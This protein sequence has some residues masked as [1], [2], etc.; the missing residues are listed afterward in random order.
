MANYSATS[1]SSY[2][3]VKNRAAFDEWLATVAYNDLTVLETDDPLRVGLNATNGDCSGF[4]IEFEDEDGESRN[5]LEEL[6]K[7]LADGEV[8]VLME[9]GSEKCRYI[10][11]FAVAV[12]ADPTADGG[13][14]ILEVNLNDIYGLVRKNWGV[15][16][17][18]AVY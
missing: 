11:G 7:H 4:S 14:K 2:F 17:G 10:V 6:A 1:R 13:F 3:C 5:L 8:A 15:E 9:A 12:M 16:A 18:Q